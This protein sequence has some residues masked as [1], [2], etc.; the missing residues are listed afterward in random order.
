MIK[1]KVESE[2]KEELTGYIGLLNM[3]LHQDL[4]I[5]GKNDGTG[6]VYWVQFEI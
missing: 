1:V 6:P 5:V 4:K 3:L 2:S